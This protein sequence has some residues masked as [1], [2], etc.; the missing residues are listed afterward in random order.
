[1]KNLDIA[2]GATVSVNFY[3]P[4]LCEVHRGL[5]ELERGTSWAQRK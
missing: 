5:R 1:M 2:T 4:A 3:D